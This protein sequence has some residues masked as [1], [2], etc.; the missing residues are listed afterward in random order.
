M[1]TMPV[2]TCIL[3]LLAISTKCKDKRSLVDDVAP[4]ILSL[5]WEGSANLPLVPEA[6]QTL[7]Q[8]PDLGLADLAAKVALKM[9]RNGR[10]REN[11]AYSVAK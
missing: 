6:I 1:A 8:W 7:T 2:H 10:A 4:A 11:S 3:R 9:V 5:S